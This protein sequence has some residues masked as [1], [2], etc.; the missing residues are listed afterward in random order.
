MSRFDYTCFNQNYDKKPYIRAKIEPV[1]H[2]HTVFLLTA[3]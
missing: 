1:K 3:E 2:L